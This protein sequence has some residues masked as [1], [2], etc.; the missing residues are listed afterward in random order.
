MLLKITSK[1]IW[2]DKNKRIFSQAICSRVNKEKTNSIALSSPVLSL[3]SKV[4]KRAL[5]KKLDQIKDGVHI[6]LIKCAIK[7]LKIYKRD[8]INLNI[9]FK[10]KKA[11]SSYHKK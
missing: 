3:N 7:N 10:S 2:I 5:L 11:V 4:Y 6:N 1:Y 9:Y 8:M